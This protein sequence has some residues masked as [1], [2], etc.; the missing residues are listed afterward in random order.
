MKKIVSILFIMSLIVSCSKDKE[1]ET[2]TNFSE[3][4]ELVKMTGSFSGSETTGSQMEWQ[5]TY[6]LNTKEGTF[7]KSR[8]FNNILTEERGTYTYI[9]IDNQNYIEFTFN[10]D[11]DIIGNCTGNLK[12]TLLVLE[13]DNKLVSTWGAC[14]GPGLEYQKGF[15]FCGTI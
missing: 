7:S 5:E 13:D 6:I 1:L 9:T 11:S 8:L 2:I 12:E 10:N 14:D 15:E 4:Y 3:Y